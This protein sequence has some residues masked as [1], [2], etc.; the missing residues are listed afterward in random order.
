MTMGR[1][2]IFGRW[3]DHLGRALER[4]SFRRRLYEFDEDAWD[5][6]DDLAIFWAEM[7]EQQEFVTVETLHRE[8]VEYLVQRE[9]REIV[10]LGD[11]PLR[12]ISKVRS[13]RAVQLPMVRQGAGRIVAQFRDHFEAANGMAF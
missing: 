5:R 1:N 10:A 9:L 8:A 6:M 11:P 7:G 13:N 4:S 3:G 2:G 12:V